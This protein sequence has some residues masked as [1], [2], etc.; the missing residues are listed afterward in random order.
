MPFDLKTFTRRAAGIRLLVL[1]VDGVLTDGRIHIGGDGVEHKVFHVRDGHGIKAAM[2]AGIDVAVISG[3]ASKAVEVRMR[4]LGIQHFHLGRAEKLPAL[5]ELAASL[6]VELAD[7]ACI[8]DDT[9]DLPLI[10][11]AGIGVAVADAHPDLLDAADWVTRLTGGTGAVR[12]IC[13]LLIDARR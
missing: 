12:E 1:D 8:G 2:A 3:R 6:Q 10:R 5:Q 7:I 9:P 11:A 4:E 13:D